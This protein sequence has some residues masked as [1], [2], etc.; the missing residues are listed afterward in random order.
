[1]SFSLTLKELLF[2]P[3]PGFCSH[4]EYGDFLILMR[5]IVSVMGSDHEKK[6]FL[7]LL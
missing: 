3:V 2:W 4:D 1:M 7:S 5:S 6:S